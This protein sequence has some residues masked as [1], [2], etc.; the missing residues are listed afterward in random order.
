[1][2]SYRKNLKK[3]NI[4]DNKYKLPRKIM[5]TTK[6]NFKHRVKNSKLK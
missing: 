2:K 6:N 4:L 3:L 1:M 5:L